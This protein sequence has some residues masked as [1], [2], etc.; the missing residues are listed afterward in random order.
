[1]ELESLIKIENGEKAKHTFSDAEYANRQR[2]LRELMASQ[3][4]DSVLFTSYHNIN[5]YADFLYCSFGRKYGLV[6][7][8]DKVVSISAN[9]DGGQPWRRTVGDYNVVY[10]DW[11]RDNF[12]RAVQQEIPNK[13]RVGLEYDQ[14]PVEALNKLRAALPSV[15]F[16]DISAATMRM[17]MIKSAEEIAL[18]KHGAQVCD[19]GGAALAA[20]VHEGVPEHEVA[21]ASTQAMVR[22]IA[23]RF[24][25]S[26]LMDTWTW[27][28]SG[29]NTD[30]AHNP[31]TT[32]KV[33]KGDI[34]SLNCFSMI[35]GYYTALERTMFFDHCPDAHLRLWKINVEVHEAGLE[36]IK[37]GA[38]CGEIAKELNKIYEKYDLLKYRTFGYG[39]SFGV[40][41][42]YYGR[43]AGLE[44]REDIDTVLEPN[45]VVSMEP[46][47]M[48][49]E[50]MPGAGGY[51]EHDILVVHENG[52]ENIT[53]FKYGPEHNI[54]KA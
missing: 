33:Q 26:E 34:L 48:L 53:G 23:R 1:M 49:P 14:L 20:A 38:V 46:M 22:E 37:P 42:H 44:L 18:I 12:Y 40:L 6:V 54:I 47:I 31:V 17:R 32:R 3:N 11:Q 28:Q 52:A 27:F 10:T 2:K 45:M 9:I 8:G 50:G 41:S 36:L 13:G 5:Y 4:I 25:D 24:P 16:V 43:E 21:L 15:E 35:S 39:H 51:R 30:G 19:V 7:T 29:I